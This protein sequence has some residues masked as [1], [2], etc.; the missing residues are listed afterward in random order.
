[1]AAELASEHPPAAL[2]LRSPFT[3][4]ADVGQ[5]HYWWLPAR[6][7]IRDRYATIDLI[8]RVRSPLLVIVGERDNIVPAEFSRRLY[9]AALEP[10][11]LLSMPE[12]DHNDYELLAGDRMI[13]GIVDFLRR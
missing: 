1:V 4:M 9:E 13:E 5:Y 7:L 8:G 11:S 12:A 3:S 6:W 2:I 10:K